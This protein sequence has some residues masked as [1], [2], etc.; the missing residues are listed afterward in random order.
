MKHRALRGALGIENVDNVAMRVAIMDLHG[1]A[2][3]FRER[4][5]HAKALDLRITP[6]GLLAGGAE[7]VEPGLTNR[8]H[9]GSVEEIGNLRDC[10]VKRAKFLAV[11][12]LAGYDMIDRII[13][14]DRHTPSQ[15]LCD[16]RSMLGGNVLAAQNVGRPPC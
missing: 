6:F 13:R 12:A 10:L 2:L 16:E 8:H 11:A 4:D 1:K 15:A 3:F 5:M 7:P 14:V 9:A